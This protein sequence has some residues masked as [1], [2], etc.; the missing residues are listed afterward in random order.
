MNIN[1]VNIDT[2]IPAEYNPRIELK[3]GMPEYEKL[4]KSIQEFGYVEPIIVNDRTGKVIGGHQRINVLKDLG[5]KEVEVVHVNLDDAHEKALNVALNKISGNWDAE[6]LEDLLRDINL[7]TDLDIKFTGFDESELDTL[8]NGSEN[9]KK[10]EKIDSNIDTDLINNLCKEANES[11][12]NTRE[13]KLGDRFKLG[14][15]I[16]LCGDS[17]KQ[18][19]FD[20]LL[21]GQTCNL[22]FTDPPYNYDWATDKNKNKYNGFYGVDNHNTVLKTAGNKGFLSWDIHSIEYLFKNKIPT[23]YFCCNR[24]DLL[25][26][27]NLGVKYKYKWDIH[28]LYK[29]NCI[30]V[31]TTAYLNDIEYILF[32]RQPKATFNSKLPRMYYKHLV[33]DT[34]NEET[35]EKQFYSKVY[36]AVTSEGRNDSEIEL[37]HP[38]IKPLRLI[39]PKIAIS[40]NENDIVVDMFCG[41]GST[42][43]ACEKLNRR[44]Y[45]VE[46]DPEYMN[47]TI[48][49]WE[50]YTGKKA[51]KL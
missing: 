14:N 38:T 26:Y 43:I 21:D 18:E 29:R 27:I 24:N 42:L 10:Y 44:C 41:S 45:A 16:L 19:T 49:R 7:E 30:P 40:S 23:M 37:K 35:V 33:D 46:M 13:I 28:V 9:K 6:K 31:H 17:F 8:F 1:V 47:E 12:S 36:F 25:E 39:I 51:E 22:V 48:D 3:P 2:L 32:F 50:A 5:Y 20:S 11:T 34:D 15:H 4:K